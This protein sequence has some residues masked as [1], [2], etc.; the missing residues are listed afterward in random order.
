V[1]RIALGLAVLV[2]ALGPL[3]AAAQQATKNPHGQLKEECAVCHSAAGWVPAHVSAQF[4]H[5]KHG[6]ALVGAHRQTACQSCHAS[7]DFH[8]AP[9]ECAS[10][11]KDVHNGELGNDCGRCH[12]PRNFIDRSAMTRAHQLTRFPLTGTHV[13]LDCEA[14]HAP[15]PQ[16]QLAFLKTSSDCADCHMTQYQSAKNPDHAGGGFPRDCS[17]CHATTTWTAARFN[18]DVTGFPLTGAHRAVT[19]QQ[20]H[21]DG[22]YAGK[23]TACVSCHQQDY[24]ATNNPVHTAAGFPTT[25]ET[26]HTTAGWTGASFAH[27]WFTVPHHSA[28][29]CTDCHTD[30]TNY[31]TFLCT[32][33]H[34]QAGTTANHTGVRNYVWD[35]AHCYGCHHH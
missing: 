2:S 25:C 20:C 34:T 17:S 23:S 22:V 19:C 33:C 11:H 13:T 31:T 27:T 24:N 10:C 32:Q 4:D 29:T 9:T 16:G 6:F 28:T 35:S 7:L 5:G 14:C 30:P 3:T 8:G 12:T 1:R 18:H 26:C 21:G 15:A